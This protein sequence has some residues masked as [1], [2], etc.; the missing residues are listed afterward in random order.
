MTI[1]SR[2]DQIGLQRFRPPA[3]RQLRLLVF[4]LVLTALK[5]QCLSAGQPGT[6][7]LE[8]TVTDQTGRTIPGTEVTAVNDSGLGSFRDTTD[9]AGYFELTGLAPGHYTLNL[10]R[11]GFQ[12][13]AR[14]DVS[15]IDGATVRADFVLR[16]ENVSSGLVVRAPQIGVQSETAPL[17]GLPPLESKFP[18]PPLFLRGRA[19]LDWF[20]TRSGST[21]ASQLSG[22]LSLMVGSQPGEGWTVIVDLRNRHDLGER[23]RNRLRIYDARFTYDDLERPIFL[24]VG[25]MN[26]YDTA[27]IGELAGGLAAYRWTDRWM[28][29]GYGGLQPDPFSTAMDPTRQKFGFFTRYRGRQAR[30]LAVSYNELKSAGRTER[31]FLYINGLAPIRERAVLY[32]NME[33]ELASHVRSQDRLSRLFLNSRIDVTDRIDLTAHYSS[34]KGLDFRRYLVE[35]SL[36]PN[37]ND[38]QLER[39]YYSTL[40]GLRVRF[41][42]YPNLRLFAGQRVSEQRDRSIRNRTTQLGVSATDVGGT[43]FSLYGNY[44][45]NRGDRSESDSLYLSVSRAF[46]RYAWTANYSNSFNSLRFDTLSGLPQVTRL[47][48]QHTV[49]NDLFVTLS[50]A[51]GISLEYQRSFGRGPATDLFFV[52]FIFRM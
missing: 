39:F 50:R 3:C 7:T 8:G 25:R 51:L 4:I 27:G 24:S 2:Q 49:S 48:N 16:I 34:G 9:D 12:A 15:V 22:R 26:L 18:E 20:G 23:A 42:I 46:G 40:Y 21:F 43:G 41:E 33:Y 30:T 1:E 10:I 14:K 19:Y 52:R 13:A 11:T 47:E 6:G 37:R 45:I 17:E 36:E 28:V 38:H 44:N 35:Q 31:R 29:G 32:G 5:L